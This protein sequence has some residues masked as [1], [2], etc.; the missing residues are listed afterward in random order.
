[1]E[2]ITDSILEG[3]QSE[4]KEPVPDP[5]PLILTEEAVLELPQDFLERLANCSTQIV[6]DKVLAY[7]SH[8]NADEEVKHKLTT[9][10]QRY[11]SV[12][13]YLNDAETKRD[14]ELIR[15][16]SYKDIGPH[17]SVEELQNYKRAIIGILYNENAVPYVSPIK[18]DI[19][20]ALR[21]DIKEFAESVNSEVLK[22]AAA[23]IYKNS[24]LFRDQQHA[25]FRGTIVK[26]IIRE[27]GTYELLLRGI[28]FMV[29]K[30]TR[31]ISPA[32]WRYL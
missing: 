24:D 18:G 31:G 1:M 5:V 11:I 13:A 9:A 15:E 12:T 30:K 3:L 32:S 6:K 27:K 14:V 7:I 10:Y 28:D 16:L 23:A 29:D 4:R 26:R 19:I 20:K 21:D 17:L 22:D 8:P 2:N 25:P